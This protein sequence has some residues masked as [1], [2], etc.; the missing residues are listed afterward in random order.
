MDTVKWY[1]TQLDISDM[2]ARRSASFPDTIW[3]TI[4]RNGTSD[5]NAGDISLVVL[6]ANYTKWCEGGH[7]DPNVDT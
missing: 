5:E 7:I 3:L 2:V 1:K 4:E 6:A